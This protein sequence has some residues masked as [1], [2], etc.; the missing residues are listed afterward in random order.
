LNEVKEFGRKNRKTLGFCPQG[1]FEDHAAKH[2]LLIA[3]NESGDF[4][5]YLTNFE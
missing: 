1:A 5:G 2:G 4:M 3:K